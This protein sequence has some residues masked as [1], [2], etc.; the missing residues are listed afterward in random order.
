MMENFIPQ[1]EMGVMS[2][3]WSL[4]SKYGWQLVETSPTFPDAVIQYEG[5]T[6]RIEYE[7]TAMNFRL[8]KHNPDECDLI[9]CWVNDWFE[10]PLP[11]IELSNLDESLTD[12]TKSRKILLAQVQS[13]ALLIEA[14]REEIRRLR[15]QKIPEK[16]PKIKELVSQS[17]RISTSDITSQ[18][19]QE[20]YE[21]CGSISSAC[22]YLWGNRTPPKRQELRRLLK[23]GD[24]TP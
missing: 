8:H 1:N 16:K 20:A 5:F 19:A 9:V 23:L 6:W 17:K 7:F 21:K 13:Q 4:S 24:N 15:E 22:V 10:S 14:L 2:L 11:I 12:L 3:F 18:Q